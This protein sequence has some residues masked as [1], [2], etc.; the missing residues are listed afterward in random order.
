MGTR[1]TSAIVSRRLSAPARRLDVVAKREDI[2]YRPA[3]S[4]AGSE[5]E[6]CVVFVPVEPGIKKKAEEDSMNGWFVGAILEASTLL[7]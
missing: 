7:G 5:V 3:R 1:R 4:G 2:V 6:F